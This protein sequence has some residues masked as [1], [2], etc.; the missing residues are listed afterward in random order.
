MALLTLLA[1]PAISM[2]IDTFAV[3]ELADASQ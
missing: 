3:G 1:E 2:H